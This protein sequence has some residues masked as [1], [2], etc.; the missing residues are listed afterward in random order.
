MRII[1]EAALIDIGDI[2][3][4]LGRDQMQLA[5][6]L[7]LVVV[8]IETTHRQSLV[9]MRFDLPDRVARVDVLF[10]GGL[11]VLLSLDELPLDRLEI[12]QRKFGVDRLDVV[13]RADRTGH[14]R[15]VVVLETAHD[16]GDRMG[17]TDVGEELVAEAF[18]FGCAGDESGDIDEFH[19][20]RNRL[21][22]ADDIR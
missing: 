6:D 17:L 3:N 16:V 4:R 5:Q 10:P 7:A 1:L 22:R 2:H 12:G 18:A 9:E 14:V 19:G 21:L 13:D 11:R 8:E 15:N 20:C